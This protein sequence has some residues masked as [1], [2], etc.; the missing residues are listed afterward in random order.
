LALESIE[1]LESLIIDVIYA[2]LLR[3]KMHHHEKVL[4]VDWV[5]ARDVPE[6]QLVS[7]QQSLQN[8]SAQIAS[9]SSELTCTG[10]LPRNRS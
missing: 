7:L 2:G 1:E 6:A 5:A 10:P 3:G 9:S 8:W 4:H